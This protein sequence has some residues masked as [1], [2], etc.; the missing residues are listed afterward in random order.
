MDANH[1]IYH[2]VIPPAS[3][4]IYGLLILCVLWCFLGTMIISFWGV[5]RNTKY[6][7][8]SETGICVFLQAWV[9]IGSVGKQG[10]C[11]FFKNVF[12][13]LPIH[14]EVFFFFSFDAGDWCQGLVHARKVIS[15]LS[16][17]PINLSSNVCWYTYP[18]K[19]SISMSN[20]L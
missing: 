17:K 13:V 18:L 6:F 11:L 16:Y 7:K 2:W 14:Q 3:I 8:H 5:F 15:K 1:V 9:W 12:D 19:W 4:Y 20:I 10:L